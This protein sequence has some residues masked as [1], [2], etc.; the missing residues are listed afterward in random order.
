V[1]DEIV[2]ALVAL[3]GVLLGSLTS[4]IGALVQR[5]WERRDRREARRQAHY[6]AVMSLYERTMLVCIEFRAGKDAFDPARFRE[7]RASL[8]LVADSTVMQAFET[9]LDMMMRIAHDESNLNVETD[10][11]SIVDEVNKL[12]NAMKKHLESLRA[13]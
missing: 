13:S 5:V 8:H 10:G 4:S 7:C 1:S 9:Y 12:A 6:E 3:G 2:V 11:K